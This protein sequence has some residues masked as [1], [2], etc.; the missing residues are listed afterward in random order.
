[1]TIEPEITHVQEKEVVYYRD[2]EC[3]ESIAIRRVR[4]NDL[5]GRMK[6][7]EEK[8]NDYLDCLGWVY[9]KPEDTSRKS[10]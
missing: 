3:I 2:Q 10:H 8:N 4:N 1:L 7:C 9:G 6:E 5:S